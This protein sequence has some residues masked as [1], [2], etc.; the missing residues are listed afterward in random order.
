MAIP[1]KEFYNKEYISLLSH[2]IQEHYPAFKREKFTVEIFNAAW[3]NK[4]LKQRMHHITQTLHLFLTQNYYN[5]LEIL[6]CTFREMNSAYG[7]E[8]QLF[9][10]YVALYGLAFKDFE[11]S[12][13]ALCEFTIGS[14]SEFAIREFL[15][16]FEKE[17]LIEMKKWAKSENEHIRR[18]A[19]EG[20][21]PRLPWGVA[22]KSFIKDPTPII[23]I[24]ELLKDDISAYVRK[25]VANNLND[26]SK[27][28]PEVVKKLAK[29]WIKENPNSEAL[30]KHGCRTLLKNSDRE[31]LEIFGIYEKKT[32]QLKNMEHSKELKKGETLAFSFSLK[33]EKALGVLRVE[34]ALYFLRKNGSRNKKVFQIAQKEYQT[35]EASFSKAYSFKEITTR[36]YYSGIQELGIIVNGKELKRVAFRLL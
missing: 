15:I 32:L 28:H 4:A 26:I 6:I 25:S 36:V 8:N 11:H 10:H 17:T 16:H 22:L 27:N 3:K 1:L 24:L 12:M 5:D 9:Q 7:L 20:C 31:A 29:K 18:L 2:N 23:S 35:Q 30:L 14:S 19:S 13:G 34:F 33:D 21:R